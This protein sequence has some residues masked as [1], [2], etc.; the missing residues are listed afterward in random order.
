MRQDLKRESYDS[1]YGSEESSWT[2]SDRE[3]QTPSPSPPKK[4]ARAPPKQAAPRPKKKEEVPAPSPIP[5]QAPPPPPP[6]P[7]VIAKKRPAAVPRQPAPPRRIKPTP[8]VIKARKRKGLL[9]KLLKAYF[10]DKTSDD[11]EVDEP[12]GSWTRKLV[13]RAHHAAEKYLAQKEGEEDSPPG[14]QQADA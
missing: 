4:K 14:R 2:G 6:Q 8:V 13:K 9:D 10:L 5:T 1:G 12:S 7:P 3:T 11:E